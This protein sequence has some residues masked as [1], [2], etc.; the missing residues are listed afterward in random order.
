MKASD[1]IVA[2]ELIL[3]GPVILDEYAAWMLHDEVFFSARMVRE[4]LQELGEGR[5]TVR[6]NS[7]GGHVWGGEQV[8][9]ILAGHPGG[10]DIVVEGLAASAASLIFMAGTT[11]RM[12]GGSQLMIHDP[13][14]Y[15]WGTEKELRKAADDLDRAANLYASVYASASGKSPEDVRE[16]MKAETWYS[17]EEAVAEGFADSIDGAAETD[18][19]P[20]AAY[21]TMEAAKEAYTLSAKSFRAMHVRKREGYLPSNTPT[22]ASSEPDGGIS[23][24]SA[25][26]S[27]METTTMSKPNT[28]APAVTPTAPVADPAPVM[29][30]PDAVAAER[31]R[32]RGIREMAAT[33]VTSGRLAQSDV[34]TLIDDGTSVADASARFMSIMAAAEP[35]GRSASPT[36]QIT[37]DETDIRREG[38]VQAMM[39]DYEGPGSQ[40]RGMRL[41]GLAMELAGESRSYSESAT[42][43]AGMRAT[44]MLGGA[45]GVSDFAYITTEVMSRTL[46]AEYNR[47][48]ANWQVVAGAPMT[49][50]DFRELHAV[51]FGGDFQLKPVLANG[52]Y[53]QATL[54][55]EAEGLKVE[56]RG[57][58]I[59]LTF[60]AVVNDDMSAF[61]RIPREFAMAAR[62]M[63]SSMVWSLIR[64]NAKLKSDDKALFHADHKN[65]AGTA[66]AISVASV[67]AGRKALWEQTAFGTK[68][69]DD[70]LQVE[71]NVLLVPPAL[72]VAALQFAT[73][74]TPAKDGDANPY[75]GTLRPVTVPNIGAAAGGSDTSWYL[76]SEDLP[77]ISVAYL[78]GY[79]APT[80]Q[81]IEGMNP[82]RVTM[83]A[84]HIFG[85]A[86]SEYRGAYK[87]AGV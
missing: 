22:A 19:V 11:R 39:R 15:A 73:A 1:L 32:A 46:I 6:L 13:S 75:K 33:F 76:I 28:A 31:A 54:S 84:R 77:P 57:R 37:R 52:E 34:D 50:A 26:S 14:G 74:T 47:R 86:A 63:E 5:V 25:P 2:G 23:A 17:P 43:H 29:T 35:V 53:Q 64:A 42:L 12:S 45:H 8:R 44:T 81:T 36:A 69:K 66:A 24:I 78:E 48:G 4:A 41:R 80:V 38:L 71:P 79:E 18:R 49:A 72:E 58:T 85:A 20:A 70:F 68:D 9:A 3:S 83:D 61:D 87:N 82:D 62:V 21:A 40:Y 27:E 51:R 65:L 60:E 56:R 16:I 67:G 10:T 30:A 59:H 55:D 7:D